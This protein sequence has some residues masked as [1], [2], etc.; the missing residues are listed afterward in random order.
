M[1][2]D[3]LVPRSTGMCESGLAR[4]YGGQR[5]QIFVRRTIHVH[6]SLT[7]LHDS[8]FTAKKTAWPVV[9]RYRCT[10]RLP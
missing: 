3:V 2:M 4:E 10:G 5:P 1:H 8:R 6:H 7:A 9:N